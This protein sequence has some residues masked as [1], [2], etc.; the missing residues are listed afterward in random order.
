MSSFS[1]RG[2]FLQPPTTEISPRWE[3][4]QNIK[5]GFLEKGVEPRLSIFPYNLARNGKGRTT[6]LEGR[7]HRIDKK[8]GPPGTWPIPGFSQKFRQRRTGFPEL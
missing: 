4:L 5:R 8:E 6:K 1:S 2:S 3:L 7:S